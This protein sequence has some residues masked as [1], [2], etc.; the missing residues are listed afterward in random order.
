MWQLESDHLCRFFDIPLALGVVL[1]MDVQ[2]K[3]LAGQVVGVVVCQVAQLFV[4]LAD[5]LLRHQVAPVL[6]QNVVGQRQASQL[7][8][9]G[10]PTCWVQVHPDLIEDPFQDTPLGHG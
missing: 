6:A 3:P 4:L 9:A 2:P 1:L 8:G 5:L 7:A 10:S